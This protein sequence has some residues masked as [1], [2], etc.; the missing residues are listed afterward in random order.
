MN[1]QTVGQQLTGVIVLSPDGHILP[2]RTAFL[3]T[4]A[5]TV[6]LLPLGLG[7]LWMLWDKDKLTWHDR[8]A[9]TRVFDWAN[10]T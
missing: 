10:P 1:G 9:N 7:V 8:L 4:A 6:S 2:T 5:L 3:R